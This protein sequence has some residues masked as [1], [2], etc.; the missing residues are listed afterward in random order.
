MTAKRQT[1]QASS[2]IDELAF[3]RTL[4]KFAR[5][6]AEYGPLSIRDVWAIM[7]HVVLL[8]DSIFD[9]AAYVP[10]EPDVIQQVRARIPTDWTATL[11][12][13]DGA[14]A[15]DVRSQLQ[16]LPN[17]ASNIVISV[18]GNDALGAAHVLFEN[19]QT[20]AEALVKL[21][22]IR[23]HFAVEYAAMLD[24]VIERSLPTAVCTIYDGRADE[25]QQRINVSAL[26]IFNDVITR[27]AF[28]RGLALIDLRLICTA[29]GDY[30]NPIEPSRN[31]GE[32][33]AAAIVEAVAG[34][35]IFSRS[36][37]YIHQSNCT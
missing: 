7:S 17:D 16:K 20:V 34:G 19:V 28:I 5:A 37:V 22:A 11:L 10:G 23:E 36:S 12:A 26:S 15:C 6:R 4:S 29:P 35:P 31:G 1:V 9:N 8:G 30:S 18:G 14:V 2:F 13:R 25:M 33:I 24:T 27:E 32:K 3:Q 21:S